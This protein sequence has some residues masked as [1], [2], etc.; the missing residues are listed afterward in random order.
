[1]LKRLPEGRAVDGDVAL[2]VHPV[3]ALRARRRVPDH[4]VEQEVLHLQHG[5]V[6]GRAVGVDRLGEEEAVPIEVLPGP[7]VR[8]LGLERPCR[9]FLSDL[10]V[11]RLPSVVAE[12]LVDEILAEIY[13]VQ[14]RSVGTPYCLPSNC[15]VARHL[16]AEGRPVVGR[17]QARPASMNGAY[18]PTS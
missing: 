3:A 7:L 17:G 1:M 6:A 4:H 16:V 8:I 9:S 14:A 2:L 13:E 12:Q 15:M 10:G 18:R 11:L 5:A